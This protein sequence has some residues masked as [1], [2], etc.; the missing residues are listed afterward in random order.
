MEG[1]AITWQAPRIITVAFGTNAAILTSPSV[2]AFVADADYEL[3]SAVECHETAGDDAGAV[4]LD[5]VKTASATTIANGTTMLASTFNLKSTAATPVRKD[6][7]AGGLTLTLGNRR[8]TKG[9]RVGLKFSGT[10]ATLT[11]VSVTLILKPIL[12]KPRW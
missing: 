1:K 9:Q 5:I 3:V 10:L 12:R 4:A 2:A 8:I 11:G 7:S 6:V